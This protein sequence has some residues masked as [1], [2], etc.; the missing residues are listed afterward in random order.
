[1]D[2]KIRD[3]TD[4][5]LQEATGGKIKVS[6]NGQDEDSVARAMQEGVEKCDKRS[7]AKVLCEIDDDC[8]WF[9]TLTNARGNHCFPNLMF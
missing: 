9:E 1:M 7:I 8:K 6:M 4:E 2:K 3:L 5:E